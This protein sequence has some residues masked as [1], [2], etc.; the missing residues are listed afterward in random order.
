MVSPVSKANNLHLLREC[1]H[2]SPADLTSGVPQDAFYKL[3][4]TNLQQLEMEIWRHVNSTTVAE[5]LLVQ[6]SRGMTG[7]IM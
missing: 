4:V 5:Q 2:A 1:A 3:A 7:I 6:H